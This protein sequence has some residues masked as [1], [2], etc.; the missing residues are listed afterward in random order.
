MAFVSVAI[1]FSIFFRIIPAQLIGDTSWDTLITTSFLYI[2]APMNRSAAEEQ[3]WTAIMDCDDDESVGSPGNVY[4]DG[5]NLDGMPIFNSFGQISGFIVGLTDPGESVQ[6]TAWKEYN[7]GNDTTFWGIEVFFRNPDDICNGGQISSI[8]NG[9]R[10]WISNGNEGTYSK[11][12]LNQSEAVLESD[13][14]VLGGCKDGI[15]KMGYHYWRYSSPDADCGAY[16]VFLNYDNGIL[17]AYGVAMGNADRPLPDTMGARW[18]HPEGQMLTSFFQPD[19][20]PTCL[21][22]QTQVMNS[23]HVFMSSSVLNNPTPCPTTTTTAEP[24]ITTTAESEDDGGDAASSTTTVIA[25][26]IG[27]VCVIGIADV[28][29]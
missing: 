11:I 17:H 27:V 18:E 2:P 1:S 14:W 22:D 23:M 13:G 24:V 4:W 21:A 6:G 20:A 9:D 3:G 26:L 28:S 15:F 10:L 7:L 29:L 25:M 12:P 19:E 5:D 8:S 16:P